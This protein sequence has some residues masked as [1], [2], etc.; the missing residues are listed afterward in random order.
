VVKCLL[1]GAAVTQVASTLFRN[2]IGHLTSLV[3]GLSDWMNAHNYTEISQF[4]GKLSQ[5]KFEGD[6]VMYERAQYLD[7]LMSRQRWVKS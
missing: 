5:E 6:P 1:A 4:R 2:G 3:D 7:F